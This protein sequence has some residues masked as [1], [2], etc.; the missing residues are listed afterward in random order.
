MRRGKEGMRTTST[1]DTSRASDTNHTR[2]RRRLAFVA[3]LAT[4]ALTALA[5]SDDDDTTTSAGGA[6]GNGGDGD[7]T[8][9]IADPGDGAQVGPSFDVTVDSSVPLGEP[10]TGRHHVHLYYDG[11]TAEGE[12]D[13][14]YGTTATVDR[15]DPGEHTIEAVIAN[16]DHSTTDARDEITVTVGDEAGASGNGS[17]GSSGGGATTTTTP[18]TM[19]DSGGDSGY[20]Y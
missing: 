9:S 5:C 10:D 13:I 20:D 7:M 17:G 11:N 4:L 8:I 3:L 19:D 2:R 14:V 1:R 18:T 6:G 12:Y 16:P 15:L